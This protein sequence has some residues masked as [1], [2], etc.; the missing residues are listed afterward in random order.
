MIAENRWIVIK[1][2]PSTTSN[3]WD[4]SSTDTESTWL[5]YV[6]VI[7]LPPGYTTNR[8]DNRPVSYSIPPE[9]PPVYIRPRYYI[10]DWAPH[11]KKYRQRWQTRAAAPALFP[12]TRWTN[13][14]VRD[15]RQNCRKAHLRRL[16]SW[17]K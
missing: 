7:D 10:H 17:D 12:R 6:V 2:R 16:R 3:T 13:P 8:A 11:L 5:P 1:S 4:T 15:Q 9:P 14:G